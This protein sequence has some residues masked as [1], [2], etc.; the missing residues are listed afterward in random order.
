MF[1]EENKIK[2]S[3]TPTATAQS[4]A[5]DAAKI[6]AI[7]SAKKPRDYTSRHLTRSPLMVKKINVSESIIQHFK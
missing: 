5:K 1:K 4:N 6:G 3:N 2:S 7:M